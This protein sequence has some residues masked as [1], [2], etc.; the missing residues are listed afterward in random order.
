[1]YEDKVEKTEMNIETRDNILCAS[2]IDSI[3]YIHNSKRQEDT[4]INESNTMVS[5][6]A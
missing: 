6:R 4:S 2:A 1:M 5:K 3:A